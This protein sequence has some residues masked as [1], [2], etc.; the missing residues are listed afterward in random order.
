[1]KTKAGHSNSIAIGVDQGDR[2]PPR[3]FLQETS[4]FLIQ[5]KLS[6]A[7]DTKRRFLLPTDVNL[8]SLC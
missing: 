2:L 6:T 8:P 5:E 4:L 7:A 1:M 3:P